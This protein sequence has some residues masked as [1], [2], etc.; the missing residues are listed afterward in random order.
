[1]RC[2]AVVFGSYVV[3]GISAF[4]AALFTVPILSHFLPLDFVL[5]RAPRLPG[6]HVR[7]DIRFR[8]QLP[9]IGGGTGYLSDHNAVELRVSWAACGT[10]HGTSDQL[11]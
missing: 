9:L 5:M 11:G 7:A 6:L 3:F 1:M 10:E 8:E 4:G 2:A